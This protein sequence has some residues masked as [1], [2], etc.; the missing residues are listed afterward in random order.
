M[1]Q[2]ALFAIALL[3]SASAFADA[4]RGKQLYEQQCTKCHDDSVFTRKDH[5]ITSREA[6]TKQ[7][8]RCSLNTGAQW[9]DNDIADVVDYLDATYYKFK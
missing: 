4:E 5:F 7:V 1:K 8:T 3:A 6:L 9:S 2:Y